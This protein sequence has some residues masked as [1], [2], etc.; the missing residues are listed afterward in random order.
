M[1]FRKLLPVVKQQFFAHI[2][3]AESDEFDAVFAIDEH[4]LGFAVQT[5]F[6]II[7]MVNEAGFIAVVRS[8]DDP[9]AI[10]IKEEGEELAIVNDATTLGFGGRDDLVNVN[11]FSFE[12]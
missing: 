6:F 8:V 9:V 1:L 2:D 5:V 4:D 12:M 11:L 10:E 7:S 3:I